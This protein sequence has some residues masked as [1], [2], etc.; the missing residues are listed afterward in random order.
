MQ[1]YL[2]KAFNNNKGEIIEKKIFADPNADFFETFKKEGLVF[3]SKKEQ[4]SS[5]RNSVVDFTIPFLKNLTQLVKNRVNLINSLDI[6]GSLFKN[7]ESKLIVEHITDRI[8]SGEKLSQSFNK[9]EKYFDKLTVKTIEVSEKTGGLSESLMRTISYLEES[10]KLKNKLKS[11]L[12][13]PIILFF[14]I[15]LVFSFWI[16]V[17]VP[18]FAELFSEMGVQPP[19]ISRI[20]MKLS[21]FMTN[22]F[23][24]IIAFVLTFSFIIW[25]KFSKQKGKLL[26]KI[27]FISSI[28]REIFVFNFFTALE[29]MTHEKINLIEALE[30]LKNNN[31]KIQ[32]T[33]NSIK[34]GN[35]FSHAIFKMG[36]FNNQEISII[37]SGEQSGDLWPAF[38]TASDIAKQNLEKK[39]EAIISMIQPI[40][41]GVMGI[42]LIIMVY[43]LIT[44]LYSNLDLCF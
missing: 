3:I 10:V 20:I 1:I 27:P 5:I 23:V 7:E 33:I 11:S 18:K 29:I 42:L 36:T 40:A 43:S 41:I 21:H 37:K 24:E 15:T 2:C 17:L 35:T 19:L 39:S 14:V 26:S 34:N 6:V 31:P 25:K 4:R 28:K 9:F 12:R 16:F 44:P 38:K 32:D 13:Y 30:C 22:N 8:K